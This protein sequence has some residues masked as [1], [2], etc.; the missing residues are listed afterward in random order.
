MVDGEECMA[1]AGHKVRGLGGKPP[2][3]SSAPQLRGSAVV[4]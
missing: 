4:D 3:L 2:A 1:R